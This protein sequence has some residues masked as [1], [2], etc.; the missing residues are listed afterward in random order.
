MKALL[1]TVLKRTLGVSG[2]AVALLSIALSAQ[3]RDAPAPSNAP[4]GTGEISGV[5]V[6]AGGDPQPLRRAVVTLAG[7]VPTARSVLTDDAGR[8]TFTRLPAGTYSV[9]ARKAAYLAAPYGAKR[10]GRTGMSIALAAGQR[11][12]ITISMFRGAAITGMLRDAAGLPVG[13][14]DVRVMDARTLLT[15]NDPSTA[16]MGST[17]DRGVFRIYG[18]PP[19]DYFVAAL[20]AIGGSGE[21]AA[22]STASI[23]A[24]LATLASRR[25][26]GPGSA[27]TAAP[28][29][30][31]HRPV[32][33]APIYYPGTSSHTEAVRVHVDAGEERSGVD[34]ELRSVP[35]AAIEGAV[36]GDVPSMAGV[37]VT[38]IPSGPRVATGMSSN[39]LS[40]RAIDAQGT[41]RYTNLPPGTYRLVAR[42]RRGDV[43]TSSVPTVVNGV[44][45]GRGGASG[46]GGGEAARPST[47]DY[48]YG[49]ADVELRGE[50][51]TGV[52]LV[53]QLGGTISGRIVFNGSSATPRPPDLTKMR[54]L[55]SLDGGTGMVSSGGLIMGTGLL[56]SPISSVKAD[57][58]FEIRGIGPGRFTLTTAFGSPAESQGWK[59]R[60]AVAAN[61]DLLDELIEL[62]P[63]VDIPNVVL[64]FS[65]ARTEIS[66]TL[67][68]G[69]GELTTEYYIVALPADRALW[70][71]KARRILSV[72]PATD[73]RFVFVDPPAGEYV[74][75][76]LSDLDPIDLMD[77]SF[78][79]QIAPAGVKVTV[80]EGE[81]K[82]QDLR[83]R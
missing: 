49:V 18:L 51:V 6:S 33:F 7:G 30:R 15:T 76:A 27:A 20:P 40:G 14:V 56:S 28:P 42:A 58:T 70:R 67:Q 74:I 35:M 75:A 63:G 45:M 26:A 22:P 2:A 19:G 79:E 29:M 9:T 72:R 60:S 77:V 68:T 46:G 54:T 62:G 1:E 23:D 37:Q 64:A 32:G 61:R 82:V 55:L 73:G 59:L 34:F 65:D 31:P 8:F 39:S 16:E 44:V 43:E 24:A 11:T 25:G 13:G 71:P 5:V 47:G 48:L 81:K 69:A 41:F 36:R 3:Q 57:G 12:P 83:I 10:P 80:A 50:D 52:N 38:I 21:I 66:G 53:L 4:V 78:L 17:D